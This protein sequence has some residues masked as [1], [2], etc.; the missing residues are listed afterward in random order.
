MTGDATIQAEVQQQELTNKELVR[1]VSRVTSLVNTANNVDKPQED[2][3]SAR[4]KLVGIYS[5]QE[6]ALQNS[7]Q[8]VLLDNPGFRKIEGDISFE[9]DPAT[10][11]LTRVYFRTLP[12]EQAANPVFPGLDRQDS[13]NYG[14]PEGKSYSLKPALAEVRATLAYKELSESPA[15]ALLQHPAVKL[16]DSD[17]DITD[18]LDSDVREARY[19]G[20]E[21]LK[22]LP[23]SELENPVFPGY[24]APEGEDS[25]PSFVQ[26]AEEVLARRLPVVINVVNAA[27]LDTYRDEG[28]VSFPYGNLKLPEGVI[29][30]PPEQRDETGYDEE[31]GVEAAAK[32]KENIV[33]SGVVNPYQYAQVLN[34]SIDVFT[35]TVAPINALIALG[36][37]LTGNKAELIDPPDLEPLEG[38]VFEHDGDIKIEDIAIASGMTPEQTQ[39]FTEE[40]VGILS[41]STLVFEGRKFMNTPG[42]TSWAIGKAMEAEKAGA[43]KDDIFTEDGISREFLRGGPGFNDDKIDFLNANIRLMIA[44]SSSNDASSASLPTAIYVL[45]ENDPTDVLRQYVGEQDRLAM[46]MEAQ[47]I[48]TLPEKIAGEDA[49]F[50]VPEDLIGQWNFRTPVIED[51]S[52]SG[53]GLSQGFLT[54]NEGSGVRFGFNSAADP[55]VYWRQSL[56]NLGDVDVGLLAIRP[57]DFE[58]GFHTDR[59]GLERH[60]NDDLDNISGARFNL[61]EIELSTGDLRFHF[62]GGL[63]DGDD[64][65]FSAGAL[66]ETPRDASGWSFQSGTA[67]TFLD[68]DSSSNEPDV[69]RVDTFVRARKDFELSEGVPGFIEGGGQSL[70][71]LS[72]K[73]SVMNGERSDLHTAFLNA[74]SALGNEDSV[75]WHIRPIVGLHGNSRDNFGAYGGVNFVLLEDVTLGAALHYNTEDDPFSGHD[76]GLE[77]RVQLTYGLRF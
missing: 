61:D 15:A 35:E 41:L 34:G 4:E 21:Y 45:N 39:K 64:P 55:E 57:G 49:L 31:N 38:G 13:A 62:L 14:W 67:F 52:F 75:L 70:F 63:Q 76:E 56:D 30:K 24:I 68:R 27:A 43:D 11:I 60:Y 25:S 71:D 16:L 53:F 74:S 69:S 26:P 2:R 6:A 33:V 23:I 3:D 65:I 47:P 58:R 42:A 17:G 18:V 50:T 5:E 37:R 54:N 29:S 8:R 10:A 44:A 59:P 9:N 22:T 19:V 36:S 7:D 73:K 77:A 51:L 12:V 32:L 28:N 48:S 20:Y 46:G 66:F 72:G 1:L 40:A